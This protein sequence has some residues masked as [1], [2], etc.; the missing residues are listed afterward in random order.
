[1]AG[2][3]PRTVLPKMRSPDQQHDHHLGTCEK[4][5]FSGPLRPTDSE[6]L[7]VGH[8]NVCFTSSALYD[9]Y[10]TISVHSFQAHI[11]SICILL[12]TVN[13]FIITCKESCSCPA[14]H[15]F[16]ENSWKEKILRMS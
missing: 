12:N 10:T 8:R 6:T 4:C 16:R 3:G 14:I 1:M 11:F 2:Q 7:G 15:Y 13:C 9:S 5:E